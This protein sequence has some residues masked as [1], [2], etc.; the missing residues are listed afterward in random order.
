VKGTS[1][2]IEGLHPT[3]ARADADAENSVVIC[4]VMSGNADYMKTQWR[5]PKISQVHSCLICFTRVNSGM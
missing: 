2:K 4:G 3:G 1:P 5:I